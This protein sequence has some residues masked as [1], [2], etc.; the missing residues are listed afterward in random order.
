MKKFICFVTVVLAAVCFIGCEESSSYATITVKN[1]NADAVIS[2][3]GIG[4]FQY[5]SRLNYGSSTDAYYLPEGTYSISYDIT[6]SS[7]KDTGSTDAT[8][9]FEGNAEYLVE[10][11]ASGW[12]ATKQ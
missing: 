2:Y 9:T 11:T 6:L 12:T 5:P 1:S 3:V 7:G 4:S 10:Y 8:Y